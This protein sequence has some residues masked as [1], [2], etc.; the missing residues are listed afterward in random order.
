M[1]AVAAGLLAGVAGILLLARFLAPVL[2][3]VRAADPVVLAAVVVLMALAALGASAL[4][5]WRASR[6]DP[7]A[8]LRA[9]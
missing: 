1:G 5:A 9:E 2:F 3:Q 4:P 6:G 8:A 7:M